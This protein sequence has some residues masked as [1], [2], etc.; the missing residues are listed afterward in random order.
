MITKCFFILRLLFSRFSRERSADRLDTMSRDG[1]PSAEGDGSGSAY[2]IGFATLPEQV[3]E[4]DREK[5][6]RERERERERE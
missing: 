6:E 4:N 1:S 3:I 5:K 2:S